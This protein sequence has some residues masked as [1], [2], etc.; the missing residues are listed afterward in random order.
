VAGDAIYSMSTMR[1]SHL[2][3]RVVD[4]HLFRRSLREIQRYAEQTPDAVIIPGH[5]MARWRE[6]EPQY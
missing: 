4:E 3:H 2:P 6:L 1:D 5:D